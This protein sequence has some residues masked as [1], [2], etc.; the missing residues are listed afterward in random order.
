[1]KD[2]AQKQS[3]S[4]KKANS[5]NPDVR[6]QSQEESQK[7]GLCPN[8]NAELPEEALFCPE[9][10]SSAGH[11][12]PKC[13]TQ[14][15]IFADICETCGEWLLQGKC[16]FC[17]A[18][19]ISDDALFCPECGKPQAGI[20]CPSC[21]KISIFDFCTSCGKPV[22]EEAIA[23][24]KL[25]QEEMTG[26]AMSVEQERKVEEKTFSTN[27]EARRWYNARRPSVNAQTVEVEAELALL[28]AL[29]NSEPEPEEPGDELPVPPPPARKSIFSAM[30][31]ESIRKTGAAVDEITRQ[32]LEAER[33]AEERRKAEEAERKR[34]EEERKRKEAE[35]QRQIKEAQA[36]K[37]ALERERIKG[38]RCHGGYNMFHP[39]GPNSCCALARVGG[40][41][42]SSSEY[43]TE[44]PC[45]CKLKKR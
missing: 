44:Y 38:W 20:P 17:Y 9:C 39:D 42:C 22:T 40:H 2:Y 43:I 23:E 6:D 21:G 24:L 16:K 35:R 15:Q 7:T 28:E 19:L 1:M 36:R 45:R 13:G 8:C 34:K 33:I 18:D 29:I 3:Q 12:C 31:L 25:A 37:E 41:W 10:G 14:V 5:G 30:Q 27:Q 26:Q 32:R 4:A 11:H